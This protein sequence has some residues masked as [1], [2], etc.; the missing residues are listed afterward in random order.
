MSER[1][2]RHLI[3]RLKA[4]DEAAFS[5]IVRLYEGRIFRLVYRMLGHNEEAK[6]LTLEI[7]VTV[8]KAI[9]SFREESKFSTWL[10]RVATNHCKNRIKH[11]AR[12]HARGTM[13]VEEMGDNVAPAAGARP[14]S[15]SLDRPDELVEAMETERLVQQAIAALDDEHRELVVLR[16]IEGLSYDEIAQI[17]GLPDGTL[18]SRLH[19][20]R[21][22]LKDKLKGHIP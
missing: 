3:E 7:F 5:E 11:L 18:K 16:D 10:Y 8:F 2:E 15:G 14:M 6:D 4:R 20:A 9:D 19:R 22:A 13:S 12:R 17:T 1:A 21:L